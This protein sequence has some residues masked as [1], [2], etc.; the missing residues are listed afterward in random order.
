MGKKR[1]TEKNCEICKIPL[2]FGNFE[3]DLEKNWF[4]DVFLWKYH[5]QLFFHLYQIFNVDKSALYYFLDDEFH[6]QGRD[7]RRGKTWSVSQTESINYTEKLKL[8][9][10]K[11]SLGRKKKKCHFQEKK[12]RNN[13]HLRKYCKK[14]YYL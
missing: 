5:S 3:K 8:D 6:Y 10:L 11:K 14:S 2:I 9:E 12:I 13:K 1:P 4:D 7:W